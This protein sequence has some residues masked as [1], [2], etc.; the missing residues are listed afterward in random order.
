MTTGT[1][2][3]IDVGGTSIKAMLA[4]GAGARLGE[5]RKPTP[6]ND[7][8]GTQTIATIVSI[9]RAAGAF[10]AVDAVG[11]AVPGIVDD[12]RG[13]VV[14]S[15]NLGWIDLPVRASAEQAIGLPVAFGQDVRTGA[16]AESIS[17]AAA[18]LRGAV[19]FLP[20]G[21]GLAAALIVD[22]E[23]APAAIWAGEVG[24]EIIA[25]GPHAG[26]R[27]E[28][29]ASAGGIARRAGASNALSVAE[30]VRSGDAEA[31]AIWTDAIEVLADTLAAMNAELSP[32]AI[33]LGGG[34]ADAGR[35]LFDPLETAFA[36]RIHAH[37]LAQRRSTP[38]R[39]TLL[40]AAHGDAAAVI[41]ATHLARRLI[42]EGH[43]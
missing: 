40:R 31:G 22:G 15:M 41:G 20:I 11:L 17:G 34:L 39:P 33:V 43:R 28:E 8:S 19:V 10:A 37:Q 9:V 5:W 3:G 7:Q 36:L 27:V 25:F 2:L 18:T 38:L 35:L 6:R 16:L 24:Q 29:I 12:A 4:D 23:P 26:L 1:V 42:S 32:E 13:V 14:R 21:T 30:R